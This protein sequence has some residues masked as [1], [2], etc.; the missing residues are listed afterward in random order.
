MDFTT[1]FGITHGSIVLFQLTFILIYS[2]FSKKKIQFQQNKQIIKKND[3]YLKKK[4]KFD[5]Y[6]S[7]D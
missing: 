7:L 4:K 2:T 1:L 5:G 6:V 3:G